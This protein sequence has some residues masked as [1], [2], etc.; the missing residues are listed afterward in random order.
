MGEFLHSRVH[1]LSFS[2]RYE[3]LKVCKDGFGFPLCPSAMAT[4]GQESQETLLC[5]QLV[6]SSWPRHFLCL[7]DLT[8]AGSEAAAKKVFIRK[9][10][11]EGNI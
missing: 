6:I 8:Q 1:F 3:R 4:K 7:V 5:S 11:S 10:G 9:Y 2:G